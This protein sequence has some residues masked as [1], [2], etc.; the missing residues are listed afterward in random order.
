[1]FVGLFSCMVFPFPGS[2]FFYYLLCLWFRI[3]PGSCLEVIHDSQMFCTGSYMNHKWSVEFHRWIIDDLCMHMCDLHRSLVHWMGTLKDRLRFRIVL[4]SCLE[5]IID[6]Q[7]FCRSSYMIHVWSVEIH[8]WIIDDLFMP[9]CD[10]HTPL[11][12][13]LGA[14]TSW[15]RFRICSWGLLRIH[16]WFIN[17][18]CRIIYESLMICADSYM[19][20]RWSM[21]VRICSSIFLGHWLGTFNSRLR[22]RIVH[23]SC[24]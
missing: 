2:V 7:M 18:L 16:I 4:G 12:H 3:V 9:M 8:R 1:M 5:F 17:A 24:L 21:H 15:L 6:S 23:G 14:L 20:H 22:F 19:S 11:V 10:L 13:W